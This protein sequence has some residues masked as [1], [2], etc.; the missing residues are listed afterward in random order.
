MADINV[1]RKSPSVWPWVLGLI[2]LALIIW[3]LSEMFR[4]GGADTGGVAN[5]TTE[6]QAPAPE[7][8]APTAPD[9]FP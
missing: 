1:E 9:T 5:D 4:D 3:A 2:V 7:M 8:G 6:V